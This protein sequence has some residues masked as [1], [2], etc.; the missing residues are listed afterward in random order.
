MKTR[1]FSLIG[2]FVLLIGV[3]PGSA[4]AAPPPPDYRPVDVGPEVRGWE[5]TPERLAPMPTGLQEA[6]AIADAVAAAS[7]TDCILGTVKK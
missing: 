7:A 1:L 4:N 6:E 5:A 3:L 2:I